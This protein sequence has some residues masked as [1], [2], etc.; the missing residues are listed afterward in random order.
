MSE[1]FA[2]DAF[3]TFTLDP[4]IVVTP[5]PFTFA[6]EKEPLATRTTLRPFVLLCGNTITSP[7]LGISTCRP[8]LMSAVLPATARSMLVALV[9]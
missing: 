9:V 3:S 4:A 7:T 5:F 6:I 1:I 2:G 8:A